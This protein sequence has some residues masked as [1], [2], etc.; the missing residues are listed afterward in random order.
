MHRFALRILPALALCVALLAPVAADGRKR[1]PDL[2]VTINR[3]DG[4]NSPDR[5]GVRASLPG[6][7]TRQRMYVRLRAQY[8]DEVN[9]KWQN[10][11]GAGGR[12]SWIK[13]GDARV[14]ARQAGFT[15][16]FDTP[17]ADSQFVLRGIAD[18]QYR[19]FEGREGRKPKV[20]VVKRLRGH[21]RKGI[22][23]VPGGD[24]P[25]KSS[26]ICVIK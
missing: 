1:D 13:L 16:A 9:Q 8:F 15:F 11:P 5:M 6:N 14:R 18:F 20:T 3:C 26:S 2:W 4:A 17:T 21:S 23:H 10:V 24:P 19:R 22:K 12:S 25:K 7:G